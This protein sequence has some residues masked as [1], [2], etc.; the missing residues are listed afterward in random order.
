MTSCSGGG[1]G[2]GPPELV[3][4]AD[5]PLAKGVRAQ[6]AKRPTVRPG[7]DDRKYHL[8]QQQQREQH[9]QREQQH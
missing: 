8:D 7:G 9:Q 3:P 1:G 5:R 4:M 2:K 6:P